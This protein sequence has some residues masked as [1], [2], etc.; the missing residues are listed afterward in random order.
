MPDKPVWQIL[1]PLIISGESGGCWCSMIWFPA[2]L[3]WMKLQQH[4]W[5]HLFYTL[6]WLNGPG[7]YSWQIA[8]FEKSGGVWEVHLTYITA[9]WE[10][11]HI[12]HPRNNSSDGLKDIDLVKETWT[13]ISCDAPGF[14]RSAAVTNNVNN[15]LKRGSLAASNT[16]DLKW[17]Y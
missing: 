16:A 8:V 13:C 15:V 12:P 6:R 11:W 4:L 9:C 14:E 10:C 3:Q 1:H 7:C 2:R 5:P 17:C